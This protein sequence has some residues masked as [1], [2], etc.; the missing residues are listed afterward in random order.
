MQHYQHLTLVER[1]KLYAWKEHGESLRSIAVRLNRNVGT[2]S[3][4]L[5]RHTKY[6]KPYV[7]C[8]AQHQADRWMVRQRYQA[9]LKGPLVFLFVRHHLRDL[10]WSPEKIAGRLTRI[11]P[12]YT[13]DDETIYRYIYG[14]HQKRMKLWRYL[15]RHR[16]HRL[17]CHGRKVR[18][19]GS[20]D[21]AVPIVQRPK[22]VQKRKQVGHWETDNLEGKRSDRTAISVSVERA[23]RIVRLAKL[24]NLTARTKTDVVLTHLRQEKMWFRRSLTVDRGP[25]NRN[26]GQ[27]TKTLKIPVYACTPYHSWE[28][29]SVENMN[30]RIR[31]YIPKGTSVDGI[32]QGDLTVLEEVLNNTPM[33][34]L[35]FLTPYEKLEKIL[36]SSHIR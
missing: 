30:G 31:R 18:T 5:K 27:V 17:A 24:A 32:T 36:S 21:Y 3:R 33:K 11:Y 1:E 8:L 10:H 12:G 2:I 34:V 29:G 7:P 15:V 19:V 6:G 4:E 16:K 9:P 35:G 23:T 25:E 28:K 13:I 26:H 20:M 14:K 22:Y